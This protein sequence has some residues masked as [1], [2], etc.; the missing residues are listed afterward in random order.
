MKTR[1]GILIAIGILFMAV[2]VFDESSNPFDKPP[3]SF[4]KSPNPFDELKEIA[5]KRGIQDSQ[6][7]QYFVTS[8]GTKYQ[9]VYCLEHESISC[10]IQNNKET[11]FVLYGAGKYFLAYM[12]SDGIEMHFNCSPEFAMKFGNYFLKW[13]NSFSSAI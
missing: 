4:D 5:I 10:G 9:V 2:S 6:C 8:E 12:N 3:N 1:Y 13:L 11:C 7:L